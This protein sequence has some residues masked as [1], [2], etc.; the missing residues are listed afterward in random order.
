MR[1]GQYDTKSIMLHRLIKSG[2]FIAER[3]KINRLQSRLL[4]S[5]ADVIEAAFWLISGNQFAQALVALDGA[6]EIV[7]KGELERIHPILIADARDRESSETVE[8]L[9]RNAFL[10]QSEE[11]HLSIPEF[12]IERTIR[13]DMAFERVQALYPTIGKWRK[14]LLP[15][16]GDDSLHGFRNDIVH[17][18]GDPAAEGI[19][20]AAIIE[21]A[22]PF[23][24]ELLA[25]IT[26]RGAEPVRLSHLL[27]EWVYCEVDVAAAVLKDL[28]ENGFPP[29]AYA[30]APLAH[31]ILWTNTRWPNPN[32]DRDVITIGSTTPWEEF[33]RRQKLPK[34]WDD[35]LVLE[36][37]CPICDSMAGD[38]SVIYAKVLL[39]N[40]PID[41]K[42]LVPE[43]FLCHLCGFHIDPSQPFLARHF[44]PAIPDD[45]AAKYLKDIGIN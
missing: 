2:Y 14:R 7:L 13:F 10:Q 26:Q 39:E 15:K 12:D 4:V 20:V 8:S 3:K 42:L 6:I 33:A 9:L 44:V 25:L 37:E 16:T 19:Y 27:M 31:H 38:G 21:V 17:Y 30:I 40:D 29:A 32:D 41:R 43:G 18:G 22:L 5:A 28:R 1:Q 34:G 11:E 36:I 23:L 35:G 24:E 45:V